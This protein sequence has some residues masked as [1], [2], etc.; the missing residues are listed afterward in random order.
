MQLI[1]HHHASVYL[2]FRGY[3]LKQFANSQ[4]YVLFR[5]YLNKVSY[6]FISAIKLN[7]AQESCGRFSRFIFLCHTYH[8]YPDNL[9]LLSCGDSH[10]LFL[11][12]MNESYFLPI[13]GSHRDSYISMHGVYPGDPKW[14]LRVLLALSLKELPY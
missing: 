3:R 13:L 7:T 14:F 9:S 12:I 8:L 10:F 2:S 4:S 11:S 5:L 6:P 1:M